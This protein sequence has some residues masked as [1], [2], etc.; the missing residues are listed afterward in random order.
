MFS[1]SSLTSVTKEVVDNAIYT[2]SKWS[3]IAHE[4]NDSR[5][6][7]IYAFYGRPYTRLLG[8]GSNHNGSLD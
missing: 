5:E 2:K 4:S 8:R 1:T 7:H 6:S 3:H